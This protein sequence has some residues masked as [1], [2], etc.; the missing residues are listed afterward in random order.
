MQHQRLHDDLTW[1]IHNMGVVLCCESL[2]LAEELLELFHLGLGVFL[3]AWVSRIEESSYLLPGL[4]FHVEV[5]GCVDLVEAVDDQ[6]FLRDRAVGWWLS[7]VWLGLAFAVAEA[8]ILFSGEV[9][10]KAESWNM[11]ALWSFYTF[12]SFFFV[13]H[14]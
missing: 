8:I 7:G 4:L 14:L 3:V 2:I 1:F 6:V 13:F 12:L 11:L 9:S 5:G 10:S